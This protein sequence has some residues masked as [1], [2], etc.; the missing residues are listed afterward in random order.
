MVLIFI[1]GQLI[2]VVFVL[3]YYSCRRKYVLKEKL[4]KNL[5]R[6]MERI[7]DWDLGNLLVFN[8]DF[9]INQIYFLR[10]GI[11]KIIC[12]LFKGI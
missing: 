12:L 9:V 2:I 7:L 1:Y 3:V 8:L 10:E 4:L 6:R 11:L 5:Y